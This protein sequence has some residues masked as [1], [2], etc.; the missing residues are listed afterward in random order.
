M[1]YIK[2]IKNKLWILESEC[3]KDNKLIMKVKNS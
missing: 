1:L 2:K 3:K